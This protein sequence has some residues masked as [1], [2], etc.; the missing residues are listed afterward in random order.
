M[1]LDRWEPCPVRPPDDD[2]EEQLDRH[3]VAQLDSGRRA[4]PV[5]PS[6]FPHNDRLRMS[7]S[8]GVFPQRF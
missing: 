2:L 1:N 5:W 7:E 6:L 8:M 4:G 3:A